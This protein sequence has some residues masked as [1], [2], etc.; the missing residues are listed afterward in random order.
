MELKNIIAKDGLNFCYPDGEYLDDFIA[1]VLEGKEYPLLYPGFANVE[2]VV[3]IGAHV[4]AS[5][6]YL[7]G[8]FP[9]AK[10]FGYEP[11]PS[12]FKLLERNVSV[13]P[14]I[15]VHVQNL[16]LGSADG[17]LDLYFGQYSSMQASLLPNEENVHES[18]RVKI[19]EASG[20][21]GSSSGG[22]V[23]V[24]KLDTEGMEL[25]I[26]LSF[27]EKL[28][29]IKYILLEY[30]SDSDRLKIGNL[31]LESHSLYFSS[32]FEPDRG[33]LCYVSKEYL[34]RVRSEQGVR[35]Y[36]FPKPSYD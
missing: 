36:A 31:L 4:G 3:D 32:V 33:N 28:K 29:P 34:N 1:D 8:Q 16:A 2:V 27:G 26:L 21:I 9:G 10:F 25:P 17:E 7:M 18:V 12:A 20:E 5:L 30:H 23:D 11:N 35:N 13:V 22:I 14:R 19:K 15:K 6:R 24:L